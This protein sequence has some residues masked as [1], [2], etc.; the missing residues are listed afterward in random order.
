MRCSGAFTLT[1]ATTARRTV[2][3]AAGTSSARARRDCCYPGTSDFGRLP[4]RG[5][6]LTPRRLT[7][8]AAAAEATAE[9]L[10][11]LRRTGN[12][13]EVHCVVPR[14]DHDRPDA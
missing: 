12:H 6:L 14:V 2:N 1:R 11:H 7:G 10:L 3:R 5:R 13:V 9:E 8:P 4:G